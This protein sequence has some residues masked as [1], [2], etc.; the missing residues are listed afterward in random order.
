MNEARSSAQGCFTA[1]TTNLHKCPAEELRPGGRNRSPRASMQIGRKDANEQ[2]RGGAPDPPAPPDP[3]A[4]EAGAGIGRRRIR[5]DYRPAQIFIPGDQR[6][7]VEDHHLARIVPTPPPLR[8]PH[9]HDTLTLDEVWSR[10]GA[11]AWADPSR[12]HAQRILEA[13]QAHGFS[14]WNEPANRD[15]DDL[16]HWT[17]RNGHSVTILM[18]G[19]LAAELFRKRLQLLSR[20]AGRRLGPTWVVHGGDESFVVRG[21]RCVS[22]RDLP[23][24][25]A[26][27]DPSSV[28]R[29]PTNP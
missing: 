25:Q 8:R 24:T 2:V 15:L 17:L 10:G 27:L 11:P 21:I 19:L 6:S 9:V 28:V 20:R 29:A 18:P 5:D 16:R 12:F 14:D 26:L 3:P 23:E 4:R 7:T 13:E 22:W 1:H